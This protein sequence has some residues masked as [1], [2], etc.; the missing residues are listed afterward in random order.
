MS[1]EDG[2]ARNIR[3][4]Q[5]SPPDAENS[6]ARSWSVLCLVEAA[7]QGVSRAQAANL[8]GERPG[9]P[10]TGSFSGARVKCVHERDLAWVAI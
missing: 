9:C 1:F 8:R 4:I 3:P 5:I 6:T 10:A 2:P 7:V